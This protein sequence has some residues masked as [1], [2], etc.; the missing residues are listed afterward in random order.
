[1]Q[2]KIFCTKYAFHLLDENYPDSS[3]QGLVRMFTPMG[4]YA[5][6]KDARTK[7]GYAGES[8]EDMLRDVCGDADGTYR[9]ALL[10]EPRLKRE[11]LE[12]AFHL[13]MR[14]TRTLVDIQHNGAY[15]DTDA[16]DIATDRLDKHRK[17]VQ[18]WL[19]SQFPGTNFASVPQVRDILYHEFKIRPGRRTKTGQPSTDE[20][21]L[22]LLQDRVT[23][24]AQRKFIRGVQELRSANKLLGTYME[25]LRDRHIQADGLAHFMYNNTSSVSRLANEYF[26]VIPKDMRGV[27]ASR[28]GHDGV[29]VQADFS[30]M[31]LRVLAHCSQEPRLIEAFT[32][33]QDIH[34]VTAAEIFDKRASA[35][36]PEER[37]I[38]KTVNFAIVYGGGASTISAT[39]GIPIH[40][41]EKFKEKYL[42]RLPA[43]NRYINRIKRQMLRKG[44][45]RSL[46]GR[47]RR[48]TIDD[49]D[50]REGQHA[51]RQAVN[52][53]IQESA[54][55]INLLCMNDIHAILRR[56]MDSVIIGTVHDSVIM[57][58]TK[59]EV[60]EVMMM[61]EEICD[62]ANTRQ[63]GFELDVPLKVDIAFGPN[64]RDQKELK[65]GS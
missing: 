53:P 56:G 57:D 11:K 24:P 40:Q 25:P 18:R 58:C 42:S 17:K 64:W 51:F 36:T 21:A 30:Q 23:K 22:E 54:S 46:F 19:D 55:G 59:D 2:G 60:D 38:G 32:N 41:A 15:I 47:K 34:T 52:F 12:R 31:E 10:F 62:T 27:F 8:E 44:Y 39:A 3:L 61:T 16:L 28:F 4:E 49:P 48:L 65:N 6:G 29:I 45:V 33:N 20:R 7:K 9:L 26:Q 5:P 50:S 43:V 37:S 14:T 63:Y 1:M 35:V 13:G